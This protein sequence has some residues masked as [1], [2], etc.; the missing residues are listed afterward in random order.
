M[1]LLIKIFFSLTI[2]TSFSS[3]NADTIKWLHLVGE[4]SKEYPS[5]VRAAEEFEA[6]TGHT[7]VMQYLENES[8]KAKLPTMLQSNDRPDIFYS[9][10]GGVMYDQAKAGFLRDISDVVPDSYL[11]T[12]SAAAADA[13]TY[14]GQR[15][16]LPLQVAQVAWWYNKD[17]IN[18]AGVDVSN[19]K[20]WD[21][22][23]SACLLYTSPSPRD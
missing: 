15:V 7:V 8:F 2:L 5:M 12:V 13:F 14:E 17:L 16:G 23:I 21:D 22:L 19:I 9:W 6:K 4:D 18:Q 20:E 11:D 3:V 10:S 1:K